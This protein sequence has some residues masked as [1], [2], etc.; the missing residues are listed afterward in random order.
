MANDDWTTV[1]KLD[2]LKDGVPVSVEVG[3]DAVLLIRQGGQ[4]HACGGECTHYGAPLA[5]GAVL[6]HVVTCPWHNARFDVTTG[7]MVSPPALHNQPSYEVKVEDGQ[8]LL[9]PSEKV[10]FPKVQG[11]DERT[12]A[13]VGGGAAG[14]AAAETLRREGFAG[15][16]VLITAED[17][18]P[19]DRPNLSKKYLAGDLKPSW[20]PLHGEKFYR[21]RQVELRTG[22]RVTGLDPA[23]K[24]LAL[25]G[26]E[27][28]RFDAC[29]LA[30]GGVP[31]TLDIPGADLD[32]VFL[33]RSLADA[34]AL[35]AAA[36]KA[37]TAAILGS[38]FI[39][40]EVASAF[41]QRGLDVHVVAP[42]AVPMK[43]IFGERVGT[44]IQSLHEE[45]GVAFHLGTTAKEIAGNAKVEAVALED[46]A[47]LEADLVVIGIGVRPVV[48]FLDG[49]G[50]V[51]D[52]AVP[53]DGRL[54]TKAEGVF[55]A[56]DIALVPDARTGEPQRIEH[57]IVAE[58]QGQHAARAMLGSDAIYDEPPF[59]WTMHYD[60]SLKY[61]GHARSFDRAAYR[62]DVEGGTFLAG[63][64]Q[65]GALRAAAG[66]GMAKPII[67]LGELLRA[68]T[69]VAPEDFENPDLDFATL[70]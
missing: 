45:K 58:R 69:L 21:N 2:D 41:R 47:R 12:F 52:G 5:D 14:N 15:R 64:Y 7:E 26:G 66:L 48:D 70:L 50:L 49:T 25:D 19:Y 56:G 20:L 29:L 4:V 8:V 42:E 44:F 46:G 34:K 36:D 10:K 38:S 39:G 35:I 9:G 1:A 43:R 54:Q 3:E 16:I 18:L 31:R 40:L 51:E 37:E 63:Y 11:E 62:G 28:L 65:D 17:D 57:W 53:V 6:G 61:V 22:T 60:A 67:Y 24:T 32:G 68:G 55:A 13:I 23:G 59:F 27:T 33:L 30:T